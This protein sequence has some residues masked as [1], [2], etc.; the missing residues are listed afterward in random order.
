MLPAS[1][2]FEGCHGC[3]WATCS[4]TGLRRVTTRA[5]QIDQPLP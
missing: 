2:T 4:V 3:S 1:T 5:W